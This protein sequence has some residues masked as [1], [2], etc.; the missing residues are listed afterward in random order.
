MLGPIRHRTYG[1]GKEHVVLLQPSGSPWPPRQRAIL[2]VP[3]L[4]ISRMDSPHREGPT[5][6]ELEKFAHA[7]MEPAEAVDFVSRAI[8]IKPEL[9]IVAAGRVV[10]A[11][12]YA[13]WEEYLANT[14]ERERMRWCVTKAKKANRP[15]LMSGKPEARITGGDVWRVLEAA[16]G[17]CGYCGSLAVES[18]PSGPDGRP[19]SWAH[20]GRRIGSLGHR[21][22]MFNGGTNDLE[23]LSWSCLWYNTWPD[24]RHQGATDFGGIQ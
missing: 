14:T 6:A 11:P 21:L 23:N 10:T 12:L 17:R 8:A 18:R 19:T 15:R 2:S 9:K 5:L 3:Y 16:Q 7:T 20:V 1:V 22:A 13:S 24:E 4:R